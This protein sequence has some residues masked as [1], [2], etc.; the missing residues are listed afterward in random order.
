M[1]EAQV[2]LRAGISAGN[3]KVKPRTEPLAHTADV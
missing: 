3:R 1:Q 2:G